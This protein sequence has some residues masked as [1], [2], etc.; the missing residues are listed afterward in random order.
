M[1]CD[2]G[3]VM[4]APGEL[5]FVAPRGAKKPPRHLA[6]LAPAERREAVAALGE[7]PFRAQQLRESVS[8]APG[9]AGGAG[10]AGGG[11]EGGGGGGG[12]EWRGGRRVQGGA[13]PV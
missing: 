6:D 1:I 3:G 12:S 11:Q 4:P 5:T 7:K 9:G 8:R 10:G 2:T 13:T